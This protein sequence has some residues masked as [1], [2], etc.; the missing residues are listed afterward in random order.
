M[1]VVDTVTQTCDACP[2]QWE[3][4]LSDGR[5]LYV[6]YRWGALEIDIDG[7]RVLDQQRGDGLDGLLTYEELK[8][9]TEGVF[10]WP[11]TPRADP[12]AHE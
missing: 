5:R 9:A 11:E 8:A 7:E 1:F 2:S 6:R 10:I 12:A 4:R 3:G